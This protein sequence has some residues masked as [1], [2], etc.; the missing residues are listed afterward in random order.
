MRHKHFKL[1]I[2]LTISADL[3]VSVYRNSLIG[4]SL[5]EVRNC[6]FAKSRRARRD[7]WHLIKKNKV[8]KYSPMQAVKRL[9]R[10]SHPTQVGHHRQN[11]HCHDSCN[12]D[13]RNSFKWS[14][15]TILV[16][17][18][19][20]KPRPVQHASKTLAQGCSFVA[21]KTSCTRLLPLS[22]CWYLLMP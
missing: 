10:L 8:Y 12:T 11:Q 2:V 16:I 21:N 1:H 4:A 14:R 18:S 19:S 5:T 9:R 3:L 20:N 13:N 7:A 22:V 6:K 17:V 15:K